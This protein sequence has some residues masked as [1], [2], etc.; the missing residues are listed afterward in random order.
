MGKEIE[1]K[2]KKP[3][4]EEERDEASGGL[5]QFITENKLKSLQFESKPYPNWK[6][7]KKNKEK[8]N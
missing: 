5:L 4:W 1:L 6:R 3:R 7:G 8:K 2:I